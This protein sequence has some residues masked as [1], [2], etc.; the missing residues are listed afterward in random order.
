MIQGSCALCGRFVCNK[1]S[2]S[3]VKI[4]GTDKPEKVCF[5]CQNELR[6][7]KEGKEKGTK[8]SSEK[9][10]EL[11]N[12]CLDKQPD[13]LPRWYRQQLYPEGSTLSL[14]LL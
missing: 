13:E 1:C 3:K 11:Q 10:T 9:P 2:S 7:N 12:K 14:L 4:P 8:E 6:T 5:P